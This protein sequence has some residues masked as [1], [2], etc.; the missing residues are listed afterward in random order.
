[1]FGENC[2]EG[3]GEKLNLL[4]YVSEKNVH[5]VKRSLLCA[6]SVVQL[7]KPSGGVCRVSGHFAVTHGENDKR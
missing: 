2:M 3:F 4:I 6:L 1:M 5:Y 7:R